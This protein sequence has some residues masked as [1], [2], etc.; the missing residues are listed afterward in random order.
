MFI[1]RKGEQA[2]PGFIAQVMH[3]QNYGAHDDKPIKTRMALLA[4]N[5]FAGLVI[6]YGQSLTFAHHRE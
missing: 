4:T 5:K 2:H 3:G 6:V 1:P